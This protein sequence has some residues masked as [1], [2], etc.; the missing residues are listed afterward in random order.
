M[1]QR[2][3]SSGHKTFASVLAALALLGLG[4]RAGETAEPRPTA[5]TIPDAHQYFGSLVASDGV[6][7]LYETRSKSGDILG[8]ESFPVHDYTGQACM[9]AVVLKNGVKIA[10]DWKVAEKAQA[11]DASISLLQG[12]EIQFRFFHMVAVEGG[13]VIEP[14]KPVPKLIFA[15]NDEISRNRLV[16]AIDL[17]SSVCRSK[18]KFD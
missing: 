16:K 6:T 12:Q 2:R 7:A 1:S 10:L 5:P 4:A 11:S 8:Y 15:I 14:S 3:L 17:M 18:S 9:S 13:V